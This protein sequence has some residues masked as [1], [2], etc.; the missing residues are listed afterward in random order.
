MCCFL[1][2]VSGLR[3]NGKRERPNSVYGV[4]VTKTTVGALPCAVIPELEADAIAQIDK[5]LLEDVETT[6]TPGWV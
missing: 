4:P 2:R 6:L 5:A 3:F 1:R